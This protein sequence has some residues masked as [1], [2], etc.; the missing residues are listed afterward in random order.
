MSALAAVPAAIRLVDRRVLPATAAR[1]AAFAAL[2]LFS[3]FQW[4]TLQEPGSRGRLIVCV[5]IALATAVAMLRIEGRDGRTRVAARAAILLVAFAA[6][7]LAAG[8]PL[9]L[10]RPDHWGDLAASLGQGI[11]SLP[12]IGAPYRGVDPWIGIV[13]VAGGGLL[14]L[15]GGLLAVRSLRRGRR[16]V[17]AALALATAYVV[18]IIER[19]QANPLASGVVFTVLVGALLWG[20]RIE[21]GSVGAAAVFVAVALAGALLASPRLDAAEPWVDYESIVASLSTPP[22]IGFNWDHGYGPLDWPREN[23]VMAR[24]ASERPHYWKAVDLETFDGTR[25]TT[26]GQLPQGVSTEQAPNHADWRVELRV[27]IRD[28]RSPQYLTAGTGFVV[29]RSPRLVNPSAPGTFTTGREPLRRGDSYTAK[30]YVPNPSVRELRSAGTEYP[31]LVR[32]YLNMDLAPDDAAGGGAVGT[33]PVRLQFP[34]YSV[35]SA[36]TP[37]AITD[38]AGNIYGNAVPLLQASSYAPMFALARRLRAE[39][40]TPYEM[41]S[42]VQAQLAAGYTYTE[43]PAPPR[44]GRPPLV[45]FLFDSREGYCQQFS[46]AMALLLRMGGVPARVSS[47]FSPGTFDSGRDEWVVRDV[48]AHSWVE[49]YFPQLGWV[50]FDPTPGVAPPRTQL[51]NGPAPVDA[52]EIPLRSD[53]RL[54]DFP[55]GQSSGDNAIGG[56]SEEGSASPWAVA[57]IALL[58]GGLIAWA[59]VLWRRRGGAA[60][61]PEELAELERALRL[62]GREVGPGLTLQALEQRFRSRSPGAA[63]YVAAV[64]LVRFGGRSQRP[65]AQQRTA[66]RAELAAGLGWTGRLRAWW[67]LPPGRQSG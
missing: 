50:T 53:G 26:D 33:L 19:E 37:P 17:G 55:G 2:A 31:P 35:L 25:W 63:G 32:P 62:T 65:T 18:P 66:L 36:R 52:Q 11:E 64:R 43:T 56:G 67:A 34:Q 16:P 6:V 48:D 7:L 14:L 54:G 42:A 12:T 46:G 60:D 29:E 27:S 40:D 61:W 38:S 41:V 15:A 21:R 47:G 5:A 59:L 8:V 4:A 20:D 44:T 13:L 28:L 51:I 57:G 30:A 3:A 45:S 58:V 10:L 24:F 22:A 23:R 39:S 1:L 9:N 49:A